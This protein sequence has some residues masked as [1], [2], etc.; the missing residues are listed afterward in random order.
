MTNQIF[1]YNGKLIK[2]QTL[3]LDIND[4]GLLYGATI[5]TTLRVYNNSLDSSLTNWLL[6]CDRLLFSLQSF[7]WQQPDWNRVRQGAEILCMH[8]P[9]LRITLFPDGREW[10]TGRLLPQ[11]LTEKQNNGITTTLATSEL[12]RCLPSHK[13]GNYL[14]AWLAKTSAQQLN[15]QEAIL[16]DAAGNWL[17]TTTGNLWGWHDGNWWTPPLTAGILPGIVRSQL[18]NWLRN[19]DLVV[20][21]EPWTGELVRG[22]E[23]IAYTNSV[24][25]II[26]IHT[27]RQPTESLQYNPHH[28]IFQQ[29]RVFLA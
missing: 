20:R 19:Q 8:F 25:E 22:F 16:V 5:F 29:I 27:V 3:E 14:S 4:P 21:E 12:Y 2:S 15:A 1:W 11:D 23:A 7:G 6:H 26:P 10:I 13:T 24:V 28:P 9:I 17:E 18:I